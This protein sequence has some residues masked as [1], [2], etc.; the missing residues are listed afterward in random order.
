MKVSMNNFSINYRTVEGEFKVETK[1]INE[2]NCNLNSIELFCK[3]SKSCKINNNPTLPKYAPEISPDYKSTLDIIKN[4]VLINSGLEI[5]YLLE[6]LFLQMRKMK[7]KN[8]EL[9][10]KI[11]E[12]EFEY[13]DKEFKAFKKQIENEKNSSWVKFGASTLKALCEIVALCYGGSTGKLIEEGGNLV[14]ELVVSSDEAWG[15]GADA[16]DKEV[17]RAL[18]SNLSK[19]MEKIMENLSESIQEFKELE[20]EVFSRIEQIIEAK[21]QAQK[22]VIIG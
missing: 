17:E 3:S 6:E 9:K 19:K 14:A 18:Y 20:K 22:S 16:K 5:E 11:M 15:F 1:K 7:H 2:E 10:Q 12:K 4:R 13:M 21:Y 8:R